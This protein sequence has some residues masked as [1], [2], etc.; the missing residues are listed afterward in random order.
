V[1]GVVPGTAEQLV[2]SVAAGQNV[3][4]D[5]AVEDV[6]TA[7]ATDPVIPG[8]SVDA[9]A[10]GRVADEVVARTALIKARSAETP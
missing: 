7:V 6:V 8:P 3:R 10:P 4:A 5:R 9:V 1:E 2:G